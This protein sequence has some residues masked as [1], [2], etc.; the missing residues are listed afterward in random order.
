MVLLHLERMVLCCER[1]WF[2]VVRENGSVAS[3][4]NVLWLYEQ[5]LSVCG[6]YTGGRGTMFIFICIYT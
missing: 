6:T 2:C 4:E 5:L 1:E 3:R